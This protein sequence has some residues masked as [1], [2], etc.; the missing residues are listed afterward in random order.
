MTDRSSSAYQNAIENEISDNLACS[1]RQK[2]S[3]F[4][5]IYWDEYAAAVLQEF[6]QGGDDDFVW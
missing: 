5:R 2:L 4:K 3:V 1:F 6:Q